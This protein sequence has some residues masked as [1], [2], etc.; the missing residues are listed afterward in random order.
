MAG[1]IAFVGMVYMAGMA[2][3]DLDSVAL[4]PPMDVFKLESSFSAA[5]LVFAVDR[6]NGITHKLIESNSVA[7][8]PRICNLGSVCA[9]YLA[10][11][12]CCFD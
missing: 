9:A 2:F 7:G 5:S 8:A 4:A 1:L 11:Q 12:R 3:G 6:W 10:T